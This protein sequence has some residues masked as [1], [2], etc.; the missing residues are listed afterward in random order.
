VNRVE[1]E[2]A[3]V[4]HNRAYRETS[5]IVEVF[6]RDTGRLGLIAKG[7]RRPKSAQRGMLQPF[8]PLLL[9]WS[10]SGE[11]GLLIGAEPDG[12]ARP[13][14]G[15]ALFS[16]L[17][18]NELL[19]RLLHR[20]DAHGSLFYSY[21]VAIEALSLG[22]RTDAVLRIFEKQMLES[23]GYGLVL[24][25]DIDSGEPI[26]KDHAYRYQTDLGPSSVESGDGDG[27]PVGGETLLSLARESLESERVLDEAKRL[28]RVVLR[29]Y[30]G[31]KPLAS[32]SLFRTRAHSTGTG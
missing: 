30:L 20:H 8:H 2:P 11:L 7:A 29:H 1:L 23:I 6:G 32:R 27:V 9:S 24:D 31:E 16:G 13:L 18:M 28:M 15:K 3:F 17:Y 21:G 26:Q 25:H 14:L 22:Q 19:M 5:L 4:L 12:Y 10:G